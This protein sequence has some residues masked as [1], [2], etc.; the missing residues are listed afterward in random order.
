MNKQVGKSK[1]KKIKVKKDVPK[2]DATEESQVQASWKNQFRNLQ[3][4]TY[5][6]QH[7]WEILYFNI[8]REEINDR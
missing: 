4:R 8:R 6:R 5:S 3:F 7:K 1:S 2:A